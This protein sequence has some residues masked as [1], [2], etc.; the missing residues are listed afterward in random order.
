[1]GE[2]EIKWRP[3]KER[4]KATKA[5]YLPLDKRLLGEK[6]MDGDSI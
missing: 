2:T 5:S 4:K 3:P 1:M 6:E